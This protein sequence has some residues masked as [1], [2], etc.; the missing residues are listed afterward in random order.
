M[1]VS[2]AVPA[3]PA[4]VATSA[5]LQI[6]MAV[7]AKIDPS[8][9]DD[10]FFAGKIINVNRLNADPNFWT[11]EVEYECPEEELIQKVYIFE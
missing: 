3:N 8:D 2:L 9:G 6:G 4:V 5:V 10:G 7:E 1:Y 11:Y